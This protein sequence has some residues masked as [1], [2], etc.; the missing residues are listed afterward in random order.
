[1]NSRG[2]VGVGRAIGIRREGSREAHGLVDDL[3]TPP[4]NLPD[5]HQRGLQAPAS[6]KR[7]LAGPVLQEEGV[8]LQGPGRI[9]RGEVSWRR[10]LCVVDSPPQ[11]QQ[12][13]CPQISVSGNS[14]MG[15]CLGKSLLW[16]GWG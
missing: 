1:M 11:P 14:G 9:L 8:S 12:Y 10:S 16:R 13:I 5:P 15:S 6:Q 4:P 2:G 3:G 7:R